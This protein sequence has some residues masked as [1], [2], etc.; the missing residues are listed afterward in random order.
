[1]SAKLLSTC[2][3]YSLTPPECTYEQQAT[4][5]RPASLSKVFP[6]VFYLVLRNH[7][8]AWNS[9]PTEVFRQLAGGS[10]T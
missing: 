2:K 10:A 1:V 6:A 3:L 4:H 9:T 7:R 8:P 5:Q